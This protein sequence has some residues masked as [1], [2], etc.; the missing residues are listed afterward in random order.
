MALPHT[1]SLARMCSEMA[2]RP[3]RSRRALRESL[4][5]P[6]KRPCLFCASGTRWIDYKD[7]ALLRKFVSER[8]KIRTRRVTGNCTQHQR[9]VAQAVKNARELA[10]LPYVQRATGERRMGDSREREDRF[11]RRPL[12]RDGAPQPPRVAPHEDG[13]A[14]RIGPAS[15]TS[16]SEVPV[17]RAPEDE[18]LP[19][20]SPEDEESE[21]GG[22]EVPASQA[23]ASQATAAEPAGSEQ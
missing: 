2:R 5:K 16:V 14:E 11:D 7:V 17:T 19:A 21:P 12:R 15:E 1:A 10:L 8:G 3:D 20:D 23:T 6:K 13:A 9:A 18:L 4:R 22:G